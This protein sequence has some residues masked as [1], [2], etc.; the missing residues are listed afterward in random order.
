MMYTYSKQL[1]KG[2][3]IK[4]SLKRTFSKNIEQK[5]DVLVL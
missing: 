2:V 1:I 3:L 4:L 5:T